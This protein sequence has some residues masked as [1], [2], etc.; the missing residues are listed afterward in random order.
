MVCI[1]I[2]LTQAQLLFLCVL[3]FFMITQDYAEELNENTDFMSYVTGVTGTTGATFYTQHTQ[4]NI[5]E[6][7]RHAVDE[8]QS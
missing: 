6:E 8:A 5:T 1:I 7:F 2:T 4:L 3:C